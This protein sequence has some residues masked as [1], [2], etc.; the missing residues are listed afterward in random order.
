MKNHFSLE[1]GSATAIGT[2]YK[3][4]QDSY[5]IDID[6]GI[7]MIADGI[8]DGPAGEVAS[9]VAVNAAYRFLSEVSLE[10]NWAIQDRQLAEAIQKAQSAI[11]VVS[12]QAPAYQGMGTTLLIVWM[13]FYHDRLWLCHVGDCRCYLVRQGRVEQ[14]TRDQT[15]FNAVRDANQLSEDP[16]HWPPRNLLSQALGSSDIVIP[17]IL[18]RGVFR[19]DFYFLCSDGIYDA[20]DHDTMQEI[21]IQSTHPQVICDAIIRAALQNGADD[22]LTTIGIHVRSHAIAQDMVETSLQ[23]TA[24][25]G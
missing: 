16:A 22:N 15:V 13:P 6:R 5:K 14:L 2:K 21:L 11:K 20:L 1:A 8:G 17:Q 19:D 23:I 3:T 25:G 7:F 24:E 18:N 4:N 10:E 9:K 12:E